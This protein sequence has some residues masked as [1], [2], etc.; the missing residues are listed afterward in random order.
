MAFVRIYKG[1]IGN[2][3]ENHLDGNFDMVGRRML[4]EFRLLGRDVPGTA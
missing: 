2:D 4:G 3:V 1:K